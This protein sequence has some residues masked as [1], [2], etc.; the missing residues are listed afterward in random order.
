MSRST[1]ADAPVYVS[2][3]NDAVRAEQCYFCPARHDLQTHH[4]I[5]QRKNGSNSEENLIIVCGDCHEKLEVLYDQR[6]YERLG[7]SDDRGEQRSHYACL[8]VKCRNAATLEIKTR[9]GGTNWFCSE[10]GGP[11]VE[12]DGWWLIQEVSAGE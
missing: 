7:L 10:H 8:I 9:A 3:Y 6:F 2:D 11:L 4:I 12:K 5:P 1:S